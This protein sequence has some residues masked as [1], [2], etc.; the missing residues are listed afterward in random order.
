MS[1]HTTPGLPTQ[2]RSHRRP[3]TLTPNPTRPRSA[4][5]GRERTGVHDRCL[6]R[7]VYL[8]DRLEFWYHLWFFHC[9]EPQ[10]EDLL[11]R[12]A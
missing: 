4:D 12:L 9:S 10:E 5:S 6:Y 2:T 1:T 7:F 3:S 11:I 8:E